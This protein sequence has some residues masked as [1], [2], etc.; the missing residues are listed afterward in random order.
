MQHYSTIVFD[1]DGVVLNSNAVKTRAFYE[2]ALPY[3]EE[4]ARALVAYHTANGGISRYKK[5]THFLDVIIPE[6]AA[7]SGPDLEQLL[8]HYADGVRQGLLS[9]EVAPALQALRE[10]TPSARW[11]I[12]S[13]GD[14]SELREVFAARGLAYLFDGGIYGSPDTKDEILRREQDIGN[15]SMPALF[16]GDSQYDYR[17]ASAAG[18]D[19]VFLSGWSEVENYQS[20][21]GKHSIQHCL[22]LSALLKAC[23]GE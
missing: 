7:G 21:C 3:G 9:C 18:L 11:L 10:A 20:W 15:I 12:V 6:F 19:F 17:A 16:I 22:D 23:E 13:G 4:A 5:F 14:Q 8:T 2:A 1:C